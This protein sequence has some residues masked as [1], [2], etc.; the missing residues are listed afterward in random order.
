MLISFQRMDTS[1]K[2]VTIRLSLLE[3]F[4]LFSS[5]NLLI[6]NRNILIKLLSL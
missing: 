6:F 5:L 1:K 4:I 2:V 3:F